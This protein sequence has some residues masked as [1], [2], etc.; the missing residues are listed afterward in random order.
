MKNSTLANITDGVNY[1]QLQEMHK[2]AEDRTKLLLDKWLRIAELH[3]IN[4]VGPDHAPRNFKVLYV[5]EA[6]RYMDYLDSKERVEFLADAMAKA[7]R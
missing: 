3:G 1:V 4:I 5:M 2:R 6:E 7:D